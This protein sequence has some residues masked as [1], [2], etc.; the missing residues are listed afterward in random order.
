MSSSHESEINKHLPGIIT[1]LLGDYEK[2]AKRALESGSTGKWRAGR[3]AQTVG[4][5][6]GAACGPMFFSVPASLLGTAFMLRKMA[7][8]VWGIGSRMSQGQDSVVIDP[9]AD[10]IGVLSLWAGA[11]RK[12]VKAAVRT[13]RPHVVRGTVTLLAMSEHSI[14]AAIMRKLGEKISKQVVRKIFR[15]IFTQKIAGFIPVAGVIISSGTTWTLMH[16]VGKFAEQ[17]YADKFR[18]EAQ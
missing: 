5:M 3:T 6:A 7:H 1:S 17:Y 4:V 10:L 12:Q 14:F 9:E 8:V 11:S 2:V 15:R 13:A 18:V 16:Q